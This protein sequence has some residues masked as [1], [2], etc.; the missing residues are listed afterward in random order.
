MGR[1]CHRI[2][3]LKSGHTRV[4]GNSND[5]RAGPPSIPAGLPLVPPNV[6]L[7]QDRDRDAGHIAGR[8]RQKFLSGEHL[9]NWEVSNGGGP[10][11]RTSTISAAHLQSAINNSVL[12]VFLPLLDRL[13]KSITTTTTIPSA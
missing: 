5:G 13:G 1:G 3:P 4:R 12:P 9:S 7:T 10:A 11:L 8:D 2:E 6:G